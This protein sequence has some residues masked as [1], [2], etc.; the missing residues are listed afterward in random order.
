LTTHRAHD[1]KPEPKF[2]LEKDET[3]KEKLPDETLDPA[4]DDDIP[5]ILTPQQM[6]EAFP[7]GTGWAY[8]N[9]VVSHSNHLSD[10]VHQAAERAGLDEMEVRRL[11]N[12][13][14]R[15][16]PPTHPDIAFGIIHQG[17]P[18][19][20]HSTLDKN[21]VQ[22]KL[23]HYLNEA[24]RRRLMDRR[25][26]E[27]PIVTD[28]VDI[29]GTPMPPKSR[30]KMPPQ[31]TVASWTKQGGPP[32][33]TRG[34]KV[35]DRVFANRRKLNTHRHWTQGMRDSW[36][37]EGEVMRINGAKAYVK[38]DTNAHWSPEVPENGL[39]EVSV[40]DLELI[41]PTVT[42]PDVAPEWQPR[43][44]TD[45]P[46]HINH[47]VNHASWKKDT[48]PFD[49]RESSWVKESAEDIVE[50]A[51]TQRVAFK[52]YADALASVAESTREQARTKLHKWL[53]GQVKWMQSEGKTED[54]EHD[55]E[56]GTRRIDH[57]LNKIP[58]EAYKLI[59]WLAKRMRQ[60]D[61]QMWLHP[62]YANSNQLEH[63]ADVVEQFNG[64]A[65]DRRHNNLPVPDFN[66][67]GFREMEQWNQKANDEHAASQWTDSHVV[68]DFGD[69]W[70]IVRVGADD[71]ALEGKL[72]SHCF[73]AG[74]LVMA[75]V[76][77]PIEEIRVGDQVMGHD[78]KYHLVSELFEYHNEEDLVVIHSRGTLPIKCTSEHPILV[79]R[80]RTDLN[81]WDMRYVAKRY[82]GAEPQWVEARDVRKGDRL[83]TP[84]PDFG[85]LETEQPFDQDDDLAW[86]LGVYTG[87][88]SIRRQSNGKPSG[89]EVVMSP[90][91]DSERFART[92]TAAFKAATKVKDFGTYKRV[93]TNSTMAA[94][95]F[96]KACGR[97]SSNKRLPAFLFDGSWNLDE[98]LSGLLEADGCYVE[99]EDRHIFTS[100]SLVLAQQVYLLAVSQGKRPAL[101][102]LK[103]Y[104]GYDNAKPSWKVEWKA[105]K[106]GWHSNTWIGDNYT[107]EVIDITSEP[108]VGSVYNI[109]VDDVHSYLVNGV[110]VHNC[111]SGYASQVRNGDCTIFS[112]RDP[113]GVPK[114]TIEAQGMIEDPAEE[115]SI[116][117]VQV[118]GKANEE[119]RPEYQRYIDV[120]TH[121][122]ESQGTNVEQRP[123]LEA[124]MD[125]PQYET[126]TEH[127]LTTPDDL[128]EYHQHMTN[129]GTGWDDGPERYMYGD[130]EFND[131][132]GPATAYIYWR[133][134]ELKLHPENIMEMLPAIVHELAESQDT[135]I[136]NKYA[137]AL[138]LG[139]HHHAYGNRATYGKY[140]LDQ[141]FQGPVTAMEH[142]EYRDEPWH[143][144]SYH[145]ETL[146]WGQHEVGLPDIG[147][148]EYVTAF[149]QSVVQAAAKQLMWVSTDQ[150]H[151]PEAF[152]QRL[153]DLMKAPAPPI[154][155]NK[156]EFSWAMSKRRMEQPYVDG[157]R[158]EGPAVWDGKSYNG[159]RDYIDHHAPPMLG[160]A[161][162]RPMPGPGQEPL[163]T[164]PEPYNRYNQPKWKQAGSFY[165]NNE[166]RPEYRNEPS[167]HHP[168]VHTWKEGDLVEDMK[169]HRAVVTRPLT[170]NDSG[171]VGLRHHA[172]SE[173]YHGTEYSLHPRALKNYGYERIERPNPTMHDP[174]TPDTEE[175]KWQL[176]RGA[177]REFREGDRVVVKSRPAFDSLSSKGK[178][179]VGTIVRV[180]ARPLAPTTYEVRSDE[181]AHRHG[182]QY[183]AEELELIPDDASALTDA[184]EDRWNMVTHAKTAGRLKP[185][186]RVSITYSFGDKPD[187]G[188]I[189]GESDHGRIKGY[190]VKS[191]RSGTD[192]FLMEHEVKPI[193]SD[194]FPA[195]WTKQ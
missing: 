29:P 190:T 72:M 67:L 87:D 125:D 165:L 143:P 19:F 117:L 94:V 147:N 15:N 132:Y 9:G 7:S 42:T 25:H 151:A 157:V 64:L 137:E 181:E 13:V 52:I 69:G 27:D 76:P 51:Q 73:P 102:L 56:L 168:D 128:L 161:N 97:G 124:L 183:R 34:F 47:M 12:L 130:G 150:R 180:I 140:A 113:K 60:P 184:P 185:G 62:L 167:P 89:M 179:E 24:G 81:K 149:M 163:W 110:A 54:P 55:L 152:V 8:V 21:M 63:V 98:A 96:E 80:P 83:L 41:E 186:D 135:E 66:Q 3:W 91:D 37:G 111:V 176:A 173:R 191:D 123:S 153:E 53:A 35:G 40:H 92:M 82:K 172:P 44:T 126:G 136:A 189:I 18:T 84:K 192:V 100:T 116:N 79:L 138:W 26:T 74:T 14:S 142:T 139:M 28:V 171:Y 78:G 58:D 101:R 119:P 131:D 50:R 112:L 134:N 145:P 107:V 20:W 31:G 182:I 85:T 162:G 86:L 32:D 170:D 141:G 169:G 105:S 45:T 106:G 43:E 30:P 120:W 144:Y 4:V 95:Q 36:T 75:D 164:R 1:E 109:E 17:R 160:Y 177:A 127:D 104:S 121:S 148:E 93:T 90:A 6:Q 33:W 39:L 38:L 188:T 122:L 146:E 193:V 10:A 154:P 61:E 133:E 174:F 194:T 2:Y 65:K 68:H 49:Q 70:K 118:M 77:T 71:L 99:D 23:S 108:H 5:K 48:R 103:R 129:P 57:I 175:Q 195:E 155:D 88:G 178:P 11:S 156:D 46:E 16:V 114:V 59:P 22:D 187:T 166:G 115:H 158:S 159:Y